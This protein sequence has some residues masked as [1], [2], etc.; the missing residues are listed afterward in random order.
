V[1]AESCNLIQTLNLCSSQTGI[2]GLASKVGNTDPAS[3]DGIT[4][5]AREDGISGLTNQKIT[6]EEDPKSNV[7]APYT[8]VG[9][10]P[11]F[12]SADPLFE[13]SPSRAGDALTDFDATSSDEAR[14]RAGSEG[15]R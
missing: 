11:Q 13:A 3:V 15:T 2:T 5:L 8:I 7:E 9:S 14:Q 12:R 10:A 4:G 6:S 1:R